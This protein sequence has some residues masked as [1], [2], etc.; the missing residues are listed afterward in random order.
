MNKKKS[1]LPIKIKNLNIKTKIF[2]APINTGYSIEGTP[3]NDYIK[4]YKT[5]SGRKIGVSYVGNVAVGK[6]Y[7]TNSRTAYFNN[8]DVKVWKEIVDTI[9]ENGSVP[10]IQLGCRCSNIIPE[11]NMNLSTSNKN[12][13]LNKAKNEILNISIQ[14]I[15]K[16]IQLY[17]EAAIKAYKIGFKIIQIHAAHGY[18][19]SLMISNNFNIRKDIYGI[20]NL[21]VLQE[22]I[23]GILNVIPDAILDVRISLIEGIESEEKEFLYKKKLIKQIYNMGVS[24]IS[25]SNGIY[26][27]DKKKIYPQRNSDYK[28]ML[29]YGEMFAEEYP[30]LIWN[31]AGNMENVIF[32]DQDNL[33]NL[34]YSIGRQLLS[35]PETFNKYNT[36]NSNKIKKCTGCDMCHYY[37]N[38]ELSLKRC[39]N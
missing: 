14:E 36:N 1:L 30:D 33:E 16:V 10:A 31:I 24:I 17:I 5:F 20:D 19:L 34:T 13:Y 32:N 9:S 7:V 4:F 29:K 21:R 2:F 18:F 12:I 28:R 15:R 22:I 26:N 27:V 3:N 38:N 25:L 6:E 35:D 39:I 11:V 23:S 37:S 8:G